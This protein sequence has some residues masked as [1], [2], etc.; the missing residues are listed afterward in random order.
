MMRHLVPARGWRLA[1]W[2][3]FALF[4]LSSSVAHAQTSLD[5][6]V[7]PSLIYLKVDFT[8]TKGP[9]S[10]VPQTDQSTGFLVSDDGFILTSYHLLE[11]VSESAG[12][13]VKVTAAVGDPEAS[14]VTAAIV[15]GLQPLDLLL[16]KIRSTKPLPRL[17][18]GRA[19]VLSIGDHIYTSGFY[20]KNP[21]HS[22]GTVSNK[23]GPL[24]IGHLW[25]LNMSV[26]PGQSGSPVY[27]S[28]GT[29]VGILKGEDKRATSV[30]Y[31][32][33]IEFA[34]ALIAH[35][36]LRELEKKIGHLSEEIEGMRSS[37]SSVQRGMQN[38]S[39]NFE[40]HAQYTDGQLTLNYLKSGARVRPQIKSVLLN[41]VP[42]VTS[43]ETHETYHDKPLIKDA[44]NEPRAI[45]VDPDKKGGR[46]TITNIGKL[47]TWR[48]GS[49]SHITISKL[50]I[51]IIAN[52]DDQRKLDPV[53]IPIDIAVK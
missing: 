15:N 38:A 51:T 35:L 6:N 36:R 40:W 2:T 24:G 9:G 33:P 48:V 5:D 19:D 22:E 43:S 49:T 18:L 12:D 30:G 16:L 53:S 4:I 26:A 25:T 29:V 37:L 8:P 20:E 14:P 7:G 45:S 3:A 11:R 47:I 28:D 1:T 50:D 39:S 27:S 34:D 31:M 42:L 52:L 41:V 44:D 46:I 10:G 21:F 23:F 13:N 32:V 17:T